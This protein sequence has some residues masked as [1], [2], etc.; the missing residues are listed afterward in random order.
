VGDRSSSHFV[1]SHKQSL[2]LARIMVQ[3]TTKHQSGLPHGGSF[4]TIVVVGFYAVTAVVI[5]RVF[6][7]QSCHTCSRSTISVSVSRSTIK[8]ALGYGV[9]ATKQCS[10]VRLRH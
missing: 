3:Y 8:V 5:S 1:K 7:M 4:V 10:E 2:L 6:Y 9:Q